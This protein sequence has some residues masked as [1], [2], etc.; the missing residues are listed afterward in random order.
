MRIVFFIFILFLAGCST[1]PEK[2]P[3]NLFIE[4]YQQQFDGILPP[5]TTVETYSGE[6]QNQENFVDQLFTE[7]YQTIGCSSWTGGKRNVDNAVDFAKEI[8]ATYVIYLYKFITND[9]RVM[10]FGERSFYVGGDKYENSACFYINKNINK[11]VW[12]IY[13]ETLTAAEKT[14]YQTN[15]GLIVRRVVNRSPA[16][17]ANIIPGDIILEIDGFEMISY[18]DLNKVDKNKTD[19]VFKIIRAGSEI[20]ISVKPKVYD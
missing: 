13:T 5:T 10:T 9:G 11:Y 8:G 6:Y 16:F 15:R 12:G 19:N 2:P 20:Q 14:Q 4:Y 18:D 3:T 7:G 1:T 17:N